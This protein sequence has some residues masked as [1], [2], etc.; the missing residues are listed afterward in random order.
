MP[1]ASGLVLDGYRA[2]AEVCAPLAAELS[3]CFWVVDIQSGPFDSLWMFETEAN[4]ALVDGL[5][6][7][8][9][10]LE[11]T[12]TCVLRP[13][14]IPLL[15]DRLIVDEW[16]YYFAIDAPEPQ[17]LAR[18]TALACHIGDFSEPFLRDLDGLADLFICHI[19]GWWELYCGRPDW[20]RRLLSAWPECFERDL[21]QAC[22][23]P[24]SG[25][26]F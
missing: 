24:S 4:E 18:A 21:S 9:P 25:R 20:S 19:D 3:L 7:E 22:R 1:V 5:L 13:G 6:C 11:N 8:I 17:A 23:P 14:S 2:L 10:A 12:A 16:S 26:T 15:A